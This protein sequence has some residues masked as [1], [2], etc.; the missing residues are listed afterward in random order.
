MWVFVRTTLWVNKNELASQ[1]AVRE[2]KN[3][4]R[5]TK[6][7]RVEVELQNNSQGD[8]VADTQET[9]ET[10]VKELEV[11]QVTPEHVLKI[12]SRPV[13]VPDRYSPSLHYLLLTNE[14]ELEPFDEILKLKDTTKWEQV[15]DDRMSRLQKFISL[16]SIEAEYMTIVDAGKKIYGCQI[17]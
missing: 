9:S 13:R 16:S 1:K 6:Q 17:I 3:G 8:V 10:V 14:V 12:S 15:M 5:T 2:L 7:V 11:E 4:S